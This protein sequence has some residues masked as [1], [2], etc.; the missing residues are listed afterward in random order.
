[1]SLPI[2]AA[3]GSRRR[4]FLWSFLSGVAEPLGALIAALVIGPVLSPAL[5]GWMLAAVAGVMVFISI[6]ELVPVACSYGHEHLSIVGVI[7]GMAAMAA[8][9]V[10]LK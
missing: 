10:L 5:L 6:D 7:V 1:V 4:A 8:S 9:L 3:T 2:Y